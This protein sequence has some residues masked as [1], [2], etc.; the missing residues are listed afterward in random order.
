MAGMSR[1]RFLTCAAGLGGLG[2]AAGYP[3]F[4][5]RYIILTNTYRIAVPELPEAFNGFRIVHLTDLHYGP[6]VP[7]SLIRHVVNRANQIPRDI[8]VCTGDYVHERNATDQIDTVWPE[9]ARLEAPMGVFSILGNHDHWADTNRSDYW[10]KQTGQDL[11]HKTACIERN[12]QRLWLA[13]TG[14]LWEDK[15]PL[16]PLLEAIPDTDCRIVLAHNPDTADTAFLKRVDLMLCGHTHGGQVSIPFLGTPMLPVK[17]KNY[18][19]GLKTSARGVRIFISRGIGWAI[20]PVRFNCMPEIAVLELFRE[21][22]Q[23]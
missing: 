23:A 1:R 12:G 11:R 13:G 3:I 19:S 14:D 21:Q 4:I 9:L 22:T 8:T 2:L 7:L 20:L 6:L 17:N 5:E 10:L 15:K 16:D 18:N